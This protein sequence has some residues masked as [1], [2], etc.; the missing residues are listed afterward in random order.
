MLQNIKAFLSENLSFY[1]VS[2][3]VWKESD[4][5]EFRLQ[6]IKNKMSC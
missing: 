5:K 1:E 4:E 6:K 3:K 2:E